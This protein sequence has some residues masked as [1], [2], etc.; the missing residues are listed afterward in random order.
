MDDGP[1]PIED[2]EELA[3]VRAQARAVHARAILTGVVLTAATLL[4]PG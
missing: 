1:E 3:R 2:D 4:L